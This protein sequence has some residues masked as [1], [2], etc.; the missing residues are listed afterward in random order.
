VESRSQGEDQHL[1]IGTKDG[2]GDKAHVVIDG[3]TG[4][5]RVEDNQQEPTE[6][7]DRIE[8]FLTLPSGKRIKITREAIEKRLKLSSDR[9]MENLKGAYEIQFKKN[10]DKQEEGLL[11]VM[12]RANRFRKRVQRQSF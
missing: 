4:E 10:D 12:A 7:T 5:I 6:L 9:M 1:L 8:T 11:K 2:S 3:K